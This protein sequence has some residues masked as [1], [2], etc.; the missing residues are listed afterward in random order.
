M[1]DL[2]VLGICGSLRNGSFNRIVMDALPR[3]L[4]PA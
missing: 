2:N 3:W 4:R 1:T